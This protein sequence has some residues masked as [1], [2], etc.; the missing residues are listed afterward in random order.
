MWAS[1]GVRNYR[2]FA[3]GQVVSLTGTWMQV[4]AQD[5]LVIRI[6]HA[7]GTMLGL[8]SGLQFLPVLLGGAWGGLLAD[9]YPKR[10]IL[11]VTQSLSAIIALALGVLDAAGVVA[12]WQVFL[13]AFLLGCVSAVDNPTRQAFVSELVGPDEVANAVSLNSATF[14]TARLVGPA[15]AGV[16]IAL[17]GTAPLFL[18]NAV[19]YLAVLAGLLFMHPDELYAVP[20][21]PRARGQIREGLRYV[22]GKPELIVPIA[23]VGIV[24]TIGMNFRITLSLMARVVFHSGPATYGLLS[25]MLAVGSLTGALLAAR[26]GRPRHRVLLAAALGFGLVEVLVALSPA[27]WVAAALL[28]LMGAFAITFSTAANSGLQLASDPERRGRVMAI[29]VLVFLGGTPIGAP[30]IGWFAGH[31]GDRAAMLLG[32]SASMAAAAWATW[33]LAR[34]TSTAF[35]GHLRPHPHVRV[36]ARG[37]AGVLAGGRPKV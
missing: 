26:R 22:R 11:L 3:A 23:L 8:I 1:L 37:Y 9:R 2:Y 35:V 15:S 25:A 16:L 36:R 24:G 33:Y 27:V 18:G 6:T 10:R 12:I 13:L 7:S 31:F 29:Y 17:V 4:F 20:P 19:S 32:G 28:V 5:W 21:R 14:N 34:R 30:F